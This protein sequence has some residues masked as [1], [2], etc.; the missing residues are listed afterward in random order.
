MAIS[1]KT[2]KVLWG[3]SGN[4]CA[5]CRRELVVEGT[6]I[7]DDSVVGEEC[8]IMA[9]S[10][11]GPR[12]KG[13]GPTELADAPE[14]LILLCRV[15]HKMADDQCETYTVEVL[16]QIKA[17][18]EKWVVNSLTEKNEIPPVRIRRIKGR[19]PT[20]LVRL[21]SGRDIMTIV[22]NSLAHSFDHDE[23]ESEEE[24]TLVGNFLQEVQEVSEMSGEFDASDRVRATFELTRLIG[25][26]ER[27]GFM[28]FGAR[29]VQRIEGGLASPAD[30]PVAIVRVL[31]A[32]NPEIVKIDV[33]QDGDTG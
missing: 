23:L 29:E 28:I 26:L 31:R 1:D 19:V 6:G 30:W 12:G 4:R 17:N 5:V 25:E 7:D 13:D 2:R 9:T 11:Q 14:N 24:V 33:E 18:H 20:H 10:P 22:H 21:A 16:Q 15:H 27:A 8:H 3:R 32:S